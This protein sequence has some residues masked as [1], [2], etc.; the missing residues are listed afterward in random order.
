MMVAMTRWAGRLLISGGALVLAAW[1]GISLG[2]FTLSGMDPLTA[3]D[4]A[5]V[6]DPL[7]LVTSA[8]AATP[9]SEAGAV[10][11][12]VPAGT[13]ENYV[14]NGCDAH[15]PG[16]IALDDGFVPFDTAPL[17][18]GPTAP[19]MPTPMP[20]SSG[21][22]GDLTGGGMRSDSGRAPSPRMA[23]RTAPP[24]RAAPTRAPSDAS[25]ALGRLSRE[26]RDSR[27]ARS[28]YADVGGHGDVAQKGH[29]RI[30]RPSSGIV[31][32]PR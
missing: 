7:G 20:P 17:P 29:G 26:L 2:H 21:A 10:S 12:L 14:C 5:M 30:T 6:Q 16:Y 27:L 15:P 3:P 9:D 31:P 28:I 25:E 18:L 24:L 1:A 11:L 19:L 22:S 23:L 32:P 8:N 13:P 4:E